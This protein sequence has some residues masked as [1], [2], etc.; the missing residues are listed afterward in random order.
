M[1]KQTFFNLS[2]GKQETLINA[3]MK[4][5]SRVQLFEASISNI[6]RSAGI[7][8]GSFYQYFDDKEDAFYFLLDNHCKEMQKNFIL[9]LKKVDGDIFET[10]IE[11]FQSMMKNFQNQE[12]RSF[13]KNIFLNMNYK[14]ENTLTHNV[15][16]KMCN[17]QF[18]EII[19]LINTT[20]L[21][22]TKEQE[23]FHVLKII[24]AVTFQNLIQNFAMELPFEESIKNYTLEINM[25]KKGLCRED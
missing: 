13:F 25:L 3:A 5:F 20:N 9:S 4:E 12:N 10:F 23:I 21:N 19:G 16:E 18:S 1:P 2:V 15:N 17:D 24:M 6:V 14:T 8:R 11:M 22:V 7:P